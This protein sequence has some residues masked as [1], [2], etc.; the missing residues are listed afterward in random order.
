LKQNFDKFR[1]EK[2]QWSDKDGS[3]RKSATKSSIMKN[4][5]VSQWVHV[6]AGKSNKLADKL[7]T[8]PDLLFLRQLKE[9][10]LNVTY[11]PEI[12]MNLLY[13]WEREALFAKR[14]AK[15]EVVKK[16]GPR[17]ILNPDLK[18]TD[19][20]VD[21]DAHKFTRKQFRNDLEQLLIQSYGKS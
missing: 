2:K 5:Q 20:R 3:G 12:D 14:R 9:Q 19:L 18:T 1:L 10:G 11:D 15:A 16:K 8:R 4:Q 7:K 13:D 17:Q 6:K 21:L